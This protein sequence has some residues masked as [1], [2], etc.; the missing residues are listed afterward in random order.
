MPQQYKQY[1][2]RKQEISKLSNI[3]NSKLFFMSQMSKK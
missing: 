3:Q 1:V 2:L